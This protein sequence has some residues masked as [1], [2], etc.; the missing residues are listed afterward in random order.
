LDQ[1]DFKKSC[2]RNE[3][4][5]FVGYVLKIQVIN[6]HHSLK[7]WVAYI[8]FMKTF[9]SMT[10]FAV[11]IFTS[12]FSY[13]Q[14]SYNM[15]ALGSLAIERDSNGT[16]YDSGGPGGDYGSGENCALLIAP[17]CATTI[18]MTFS[19]FSTEVSYD[20]LYIYDG[21]N[22]SSP[23]LIALSGTNLSPPPI[24]ANSGYMY[25][26]F[27]SDFG[28]QYSGWIA[29]WHA[30]TFSTGYPNA[31]FS[32][33]THFTP[34]NVAVNFSDIST[35]SPD[36]WFWDFGDGD[37]S[38]EQ[39]PVHAYATPGTFIVRLISFACSLAD[40]AY[41]TINVQ[42]A[43]S[44]FV[45]PDTLFANLSCGDSITLQIILKNLNGGDLVYSVNGINGI[46]MLV[47]KYGT[48]FFPNAI[49]SINTFFTNYILTE[50]DSTNPQV[51]D[52]LLTIN[53]ILLIPTQE[54]AIPS[55]MAQLA[56]V[57]N[58]FL[59]RGGMIIQC[60][61]SP[62]LDT[63]IT[64]TNL[65]SGNF[66][67]DASISPYYLSVDSSQNPILKDISATSFP[68]P[69]A[70]NIM[71]ILNTD[72]HTLVSYL[73]YD[74]VSL[75]YV[76]NGKVVF[77][78][79]DYY[80]S[81]YETKKI[82]AN[83]VEWSGTSNFFPQWITVDPDSGLVNAGDSAIIFVHINAA[84]LSP[85]DHETILY[86]STNDPANPIIPVVCHLHISGSFPIA[87]L[88]IPETIDSTA[89][90]AGIFNVSLDQ[91][92]QSSAGV[93]NGYE[94]Y[95]CTDT[96]TLIAG[97]VYNFNVTTGNVAHESVSAWIDFDNSGSFSSI[98]RIYS[99]SAVLTNHSGMIT[100]PNASVYSA[101]LR[102]RVGSN[103]AG[104]PR[105]DG[106]TDVLHG[107]Y[108]DYTVFIAP[109]NSTQESEIGVLSV[110]PNPFNE[111]I[112]LHF[113]NQSSEKAQMKISHALGRIVL[114]KTIE[115]K[116]QTFNLSELQDGIYFMSIQTGS[117]MY[118]KKIVK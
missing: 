68:A 73:G 91:I 8:C 27:V 6:M 97:S 55:V 22:D 117:G 79:F 75:R 69:S 39:N 113:A 19:S 67:I 116:D 58:N 41:D 5:F 83:T 59:R 23:L 62:G 42:S 49:A 10:I 101:P 47:L 50:T 104:Q 92:N 32:V 115:I 93:E 81:I 44:A 35:G 16:F 87:A 52:S 11:I 108:E 103:I 54:T 63:C 18:T 57:L 31:G 4:A 21:Q 114:N 24:I 70:T 72:R 82:I 3:A 90:G 30:S 1:N 112:A 94:D 66:V 9:P 74:A 40:T 51:I 56:P 46:N 86:I 76:E 38:V 77:L 106:C 111:T 98:E 26:H 84:G 89:T 95:T 43:P 20:S 102:M 53:N 29:N 37:T 36:G 12:F 71:Q 80:S 28:N 17:P 60:G 14:T 118:C 45:Q 105:P 107:Q 15:C 110:K 64:V 7:F 100:I 2:F 65:W 96:T 13:A 33:N 88:C 78:A 85:G 61:D 25:C 34:L 109:L 99:D 48:N